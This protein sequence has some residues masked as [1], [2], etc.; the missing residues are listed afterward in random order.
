MFGVNCSLV[1]SVTLSRTGFSMRARTSLMA[2]R[3]TMAE[4]IPRMN[5]WLSWNCCRVFTHSGVSE[6][7]VIEAATATSEVKSSVGG[8]AVRARL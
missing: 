7:E 2:T 1:F 4:R 5:A 3:T 8:A 6:G